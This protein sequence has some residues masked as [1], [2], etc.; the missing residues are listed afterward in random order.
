MIARKH[1]KPASDWPETTSE[2]TWQS[3]KRQS[4]PSKVLRFTERLLNFQA[5]VNTR[6]GGSQMASN[7]SVDRTWRWLVEQRTNY[8]NVGLFAL[9]F[10]W[11][12]TLRHRLSAW[13]STGA[14]G[15][16]EK[17]RVWTV[18]GTS[19]RLLLGWKCKRLHFSVHFRNWKSTYGLMAPA[20]LIECDQTVA[21]CRQ[22]EANRDY[23]TAYGTSKRSIFDGMETRKD[24][25]LQYIFQTNWPA[26]LFRNSRTSCDQM[27]ADSNL[28]FFTYGEKCTLLEHLDC[29]EIATVPVWKICRE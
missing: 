6:V 26:V 25:I 2:T 16:R 5:R 7:G 17:S 29:A 14:S 13:E 12:S 3:I 27:A 21:S 28:R 24:S 4:S 22:R 15:H 18:Y 9:I 8:S 23:W 19:T 10:V 20:L 11:Y 1:P